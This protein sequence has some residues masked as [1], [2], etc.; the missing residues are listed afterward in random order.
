MALV[1]AF[2]FVVIIAGGWSVVR[3]TQ[4]RRMLVRQ[5]LSRLAS[6]QQSLD[7]LGRSVSDFEAGTAAALERLRQHRTASLG[8][9]AVD[10]WAGLERLARRADPA[11][12]TSPS[13]PPAFASAMLWEMATRASAWQL[14]R[15]SDDDLRHLIDPTSAVGRR[16]VRT[17]PAVVEPAGPAKVSLP[18]HAPGEHRSER[19]GLPDFNRD[20]LVAVRP[21]PAVRR[22]RRRLPEVA[23]T[24][25]WT[26]TGELR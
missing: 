17:V 20:Q 4:A 1:I 8:G 18:A 2:F 7:E 13:S 6:Q 26:V 9:T 21:A 16:P 11:R 22:F 3:T 15:S 10:A 12:S 19:H 14:L 23:L 5:A 24:T 25:W